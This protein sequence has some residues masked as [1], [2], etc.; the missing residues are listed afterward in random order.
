MTKQTDWIKVMEKSP[1]RRK[2]R[3]SKLKREPIG[4]SAEDVK[5]ATVLAAQEWRCARCHDV[6]AARTMVLIG[7]RVICPSCADIER[8]WKDQDR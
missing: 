6:G 7:D 1:A 4:V 8:V 5:R 2:H 3:A